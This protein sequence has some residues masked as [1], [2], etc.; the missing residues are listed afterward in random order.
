MTEATQ[1]RMSSDDR[2]EHLLNSGVELLQRRP[3]HEVS[4]EEIAE[5]A[6]VSKGLLYHYFPTKT[7]FIVAALRR[8]QTE[9]AE[10]LRPNPKLPAVERLD[11]SLDAFLDYVEEH[12]TPYIEIFR[13]GGDPEIMGVLDEGRNQ[14]LET[15]LEAL[16]GWED[17]PVP[18]DRTP[19]LEIAVQGWLFF[20]EGAV[21]RWLEHGGLERIQLR[22]MLRSALGGAVFSAAAAQAEG[23]SDP[24]G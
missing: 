4:I 9:L 3:H 20:V 5:A 8:G 16:G 15:M 7:D 22:V 19:A 13:R 14:Q 17:S 2:R 18:T 6:G 1:A 23:N 21:L 11:A 10:K 12:P 24:A